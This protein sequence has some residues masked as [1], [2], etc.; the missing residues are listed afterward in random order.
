MV[1]WLRILIGSIVMGYGLYGLFKI[2]TLPMGLIPNQIDVIVNNL[3]LVISFF[4]ILIGYWIT[5]LHK[6]EGEDERDNNKE[7][8]TNDKESN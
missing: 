1:S 2:P 4:I 3:S 6:K 8:T 7:S 5:G